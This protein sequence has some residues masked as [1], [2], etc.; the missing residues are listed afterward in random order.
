MSKSMIISAALVAGIAS[1]AAQSASVSEDTLFTMAPGGADQLLTS[2]DFHMDGDI[3]LVPIEPAF[4][5]DWDTGI[6]TAQT[7]CGTPSQDAVQ[8]ATGAGKKP[9][10][11][12]AITLDNG[13][14]KKGKL[15]TQQP[16]AKKKKKKN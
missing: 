2:D 4:Q 9:K 7:C 6:K 3:P 10:P 12:G 8:G 14:K 5:D 11:A 13:I 16:A 1:T 15:K